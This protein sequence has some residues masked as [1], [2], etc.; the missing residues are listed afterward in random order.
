MKTVKKMAASYIGGALIRAVKVLLVFIAA[1]IVFQG[2][3]LVMIFIKD[4]AMAIMV[5]IA[6][7]LGL[8]YI[9]FGED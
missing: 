4:L 7:L 8:G 6:I 2:F 1:Y 5:Y 9:F 3:A